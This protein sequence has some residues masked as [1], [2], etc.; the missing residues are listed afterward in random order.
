MSGPEAA[1]WLY[2]LLSLRLLSL[3]QPTPT[4]TLVPMFLQQLILKAEA[5]DCH[6]LGVGYYI[7]VVEECQGYW[8]ASYK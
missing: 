5:F 1:R 2:L 4:L 7:Y 6:S 8:N 3:C